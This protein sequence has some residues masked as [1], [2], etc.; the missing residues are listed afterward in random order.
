MG[1]APALLV[2]EDGV[3]LLLE[4]EVGAGPLLELEVGAG[5]IEN[6]AVPQVMSISPN[7]AMLWEFGAP[8][9]RSVSGTKA[10]NLISRVSRTFFTTARKRF[11]D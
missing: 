10:R 11:K 2:P 5:L 8:G 9:R 4:L 3:G 1:S 6:L 7:F